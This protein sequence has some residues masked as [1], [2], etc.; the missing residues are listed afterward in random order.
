MTGHS[1]FGCIDALFNREI[2]ALFSLRFADPVSSRKTSDSSSSLPWTNGIGLLSSSLGSQRDTKG[3][4]TI[5]RGRIAFENDSSAHAIVSKSQQELSV[6]KDEE[7]P[8]QPIKLELQGNIAEVLRLIRM[9]TVP[10]GRVEIVGTVRFSLKLNKKEFERLTQHD[11]MYILRSIMSKSEA[12]VQIEHAF[13]KEDLPHANISGAFDSVLKAY[14]IL[15][16]VLDSKHSGKEEIRG[17]V[18]EMLSQKNQI[19][20]DMTLDFP[21]VWGTLQESSTVDP[22]SSLQSSPVSQHVADW[23]GSCHLANN[24]I[25]NNTNYQFSAKE[26]SSLASLPSP[27]AGPI[28]SSPSPSFASTHGPTSKKEEIISRSLPISA[29]LGGVVVGRGGTM[30]NRVRRDF[31]VEVDINPGETSVRLKGPK[32][33]VD[34]AFR[35]YEK[36]L[37]HALRKR[38]EYHTLPRF[39][40][41]EEQQTHEGDETTQDM[42]NPSSS[43]NISASLPTTTFLHPSPAQHTHSSLPNMMPVND[44]QFNDGFVGDRNLFDELLPS[45]RH[46]QW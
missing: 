1:L 27:T 25:S 13:G 16:E 6:Q 29:D 22:F 39:K 17:L 14:E 38:G 33:A 45:M 34:A 9:L 40:F 28:S 10:D 35:F 15:S 41:S 26:M 18:D 12:F 32:S 44:S 20:A 5:R 2:S 46:R 8:Q 4:D 24:N 30:I 31:G 3:V 11:E 42:F 7:E 36:K 37:E 19:V 43:C 23:L 21:G